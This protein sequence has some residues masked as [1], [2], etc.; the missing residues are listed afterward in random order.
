MIRRQ[1]VQECNILDNIFTFFVVAEWAHHERPYFAIMLLDFEKAYD[2]VDWYFLEGTLLRLGFPQE[3][4]ASI[5]A[6]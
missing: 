2:R 6:L 1:A 4:I 5:S 3:W